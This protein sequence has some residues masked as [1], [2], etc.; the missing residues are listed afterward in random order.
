MF[1]RS[2]LGGNSKELYRSISSLRRFQE[3]GIKIALEARYKPSGLILK[4]K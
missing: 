3:L 1:L 4:R 2:N